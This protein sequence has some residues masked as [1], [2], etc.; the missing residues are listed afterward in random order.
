MILFYIFCAALGFVIG[1]VL[2]DLFPL[3]GQSQMGGGGIIHSS[4]VERIRRQIELEN[5]T[6][7]LED[8]EK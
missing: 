4:D 5:Q 7:L 3:R 2:Y 1:C 6:R 8:T